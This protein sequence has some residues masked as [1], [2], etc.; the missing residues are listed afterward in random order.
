MQQDG[1]VVF[2][3]AATGRFGLHMADGSH[4][5]G[6]QLDTQALSVG[7]SLVGRADMVG[8]ERLD[9]ANTAVAYSVFISAYGLS[10][11]ALEQEFRG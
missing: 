5:L 9:D 10:R 2:A 1:I 11:E 3:D 4:A 8:H 7:Q 6:E